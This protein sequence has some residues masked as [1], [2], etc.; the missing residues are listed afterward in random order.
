MLR[1]LTR[2]MQA[3][4]GLVRQDHPGDASPPPSEPVPVSQEVLNRTAAEV[5]IDPPQFP[6]IRR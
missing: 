3:L 5:A 2:I 4:H 6:V 1:L